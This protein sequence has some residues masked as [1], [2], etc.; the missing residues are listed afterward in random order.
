[1]I[2]H[3]N[4]DCCWSEHAKTFDE[5]ADL[6]EAARPGYPVELVDCVISVSGIPPGGKI[7]EVGSGT[8]KATEQFSWRKYSILCI[9]PGESLTSV[10]AKKFQRFSNVRIE[11]VAFEDWD[12]R[13]DD[14]DLIIS[15]QAWHWVPTEVGYAKA[16]RALKPNGY[17]ALFWNTYPDPSAEL[18]VDL[19]R[20]YQKHAPEMAERSTST[21]ELIKL[22]GIE[23]ANSGYFEDVFVKRFPWSVKYNTREY[24][25]LLSTYSDH[26]SLS[27]ETQTN[28]F[29]GIAKVIDQLGGTIEKPYIA[30]V[31]IA[32]KKEWA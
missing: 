14:F 30:V 8:G 29:E 32:R 7:L 31:Y 1:M 24:L 25:D 23:I 15:A 10:A 16:A 5:V 17:I 19:N 26:I 6:Y 20:V 18:F 27:P 21:D 3:A 12:V 9:E 22:R 11:T 2:D 4:Q 28:L 13:E